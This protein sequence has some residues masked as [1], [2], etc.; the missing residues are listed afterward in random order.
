LGS[1]V[2]DRIPFT[3]YYPAIVLATLLGGFWLG[4]LASILSALVAW[5]MFMTAS[6][7][8]RSMRHN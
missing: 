8:L 1:F 2:H 4:M 6:W 3:T 5:W 7:G